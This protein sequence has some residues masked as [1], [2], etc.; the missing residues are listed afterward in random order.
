[1][2]DVLGPHHVDHVLASWYAAD[3]RSDVLVAVDVS[4]SMAAWAPGTSLP[5]IDVVRDG[6]G[7]LVGL[8]PDDSRLAVWRF[9]TRLDGPRDHQALLAPHVLDRAG[10]AAV[11][12]AVGRLAPQDTGTGLHDT[13]LAAY[14]AARDTARPD[15]PSHVVVFTDGHNEADEPTLALA[16]LGGRLAAAKDPGRPVELTVVTFGGRSEAAAL[17]A[18]LEPVGGYVDPLERADQVGAAFV[19]AAAG[20]LH[21]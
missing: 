2:L 10:R 3:R 17:K 18:A 13:I 8:L 21:G 19:H 7:Q 14:E 4:G 9:G 20:G 12:R 11:T 5:L 1:M 15:V 16:E 6:I